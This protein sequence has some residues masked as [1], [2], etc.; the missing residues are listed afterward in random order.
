MS[1]KVYETVQTCF[2]TTKLFKKP[3]GLL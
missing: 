3:I 2:I 1:Y